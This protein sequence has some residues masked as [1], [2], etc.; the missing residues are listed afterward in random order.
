[1]RAF[2]TSLLVLLLSMSLCS[3]VL[4]GE[5]WRITSLDWPPYSD[6]KVLTQGKSIQKLKKLLEK[7]S[8]EL[9]VEFYPWARARDIALQTEYIGYFPAWPEEVEEGFIASSPVDWSEI[10]VMTYAGSGLEW[11]DMDALFQV[12]VGLVKNYEYPE[13]VASLARKWSKN[14]D[15][16]PDEMALLRKLADERI[17]V[18]ITSPSVMLYLAR[19]LDID[20]IRV[21]KRICRNPLVMAF[22]DTPE[23]MK[24]L[25]LLDRMIQ[26]TPRED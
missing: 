9:V 2:I 13:I 26:N 22:K 4:A 20:N 12:K 21:L 17:K 10:A 25:R 15:A 18:A 6:S 8:I 23:N 7:E 3:T 11:T 5:V 24:R 14:V 1:M 16:T 19:Q